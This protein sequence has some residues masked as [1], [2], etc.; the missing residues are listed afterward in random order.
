MK[1]CDSLKSLS[2][3][4]YSFSDYNSFT[5]ESKII[6]RVWWLDTTSLK[7]MK[8]GDEK[9]DSFN[10]YHDSLHLSSMN[11]ELIDNE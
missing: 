4:R 5:I 9:E 10:F 8:I 7:E 6:I 1:N 3:D 11:S 2:I